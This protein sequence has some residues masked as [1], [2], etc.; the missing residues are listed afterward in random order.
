MKVRLSRAAEADLKIQ[1]DWLV[2][3][4]PAAAEK[5][6]QRL[7]DAI[8]LLAEFPRLGLAA[9][10]RIREKHVRF[11]RDG[12]V[13]RYQIRPGEIFVRRIYHSMQDRS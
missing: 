12:F 2:E 6:G 5:A 10:G 3:R 1:I 7:F 13:I 11:G 4:S 9:D 8:G